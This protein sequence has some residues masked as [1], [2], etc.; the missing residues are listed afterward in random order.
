SAFVGTG[1][2][3]N[4]SINAMEMEYTAQQKDLFMG[5]LTKTGN[6]LFDSF[7]VIQK[8]ISEVNQTLE[9]LARESKET[10]NLSN[11]NTVV[12][13]TMNKNFDR[14]SLIISQNEEIVNALNSRTMEIN[15]IVDLIKD[16]ADQTNLL[17]LNAAIEAAR[18][19][20]HGRG[21]AV[22]ADEV[23]KLAERTTKATTEI[24]ITISTLQQEANEMLQSSQE[25]DKIATESTKSVA[26]LKTSLDTFNTN[27]NAVHQSSIYM[28]HQ[29]FI[30]LAKIDHILFKADTL[31]HILQEE[32]ILNED[33]TT[34]KFSNWYHS[35]E[36]GD[37]THTKS[38][39]LLERPHLSVHENVGKI[40]SIMQTSNALIEHKQDIKH[41]YIAMQDASNELLQTL[42]AML[43][44][45]NHA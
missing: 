27:S 29:N 38:F 6:S 18:A 36:I 25:L 4:K 23:R 30:V 19:G 21:F 13:N 37:F 28:K 41:H 31:D 26:T 22:V 45:V 9:K 1:Q 16:I 17:A 14:L 8:Q 34:C 15:T 7:L 3:I 40:F 35:T 11:Q 43:T 12:M 33:H 24:T 20:E 32:P 44:E 10:A 39:K 5:E 2:L 42:D